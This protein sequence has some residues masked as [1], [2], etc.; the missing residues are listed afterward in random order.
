[1][2]PVAQALAFL[3][4]SAGQQNLYRA[5]GRHADMFVVQHIGKVHLVQA[6]NRMGLVGGNRQPVAAVGARLQAGQIGCIPADAHGGAPFV[7]TTHHLRAYTFFQ[8]DADVGVRRLL[9]ETGNIFGQRFGHHRGRHQHTHLALHALAVGRHLL[10]HMV[11]RCEQRASV[12]QQCLPCR[13]GPQA[14]LLAQKQIS[15]HLVLQLRQTLADGRRHQR[16]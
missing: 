13:G 14:A 2:H 12:L 6:G 16:F 10:L 1:M 8:C 5:Q 11:G 7:Y 15:T 3:R 4:R 9:Q